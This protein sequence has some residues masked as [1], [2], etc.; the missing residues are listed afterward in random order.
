MSHFRITSEKDA[1]T[2][3]FNSKSGVPKS[4]NGVAF[5]IIFAAVTA[6][7]FFITQ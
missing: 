3:S 5:F 2:S 1:H 6:L 7:Y 4:D